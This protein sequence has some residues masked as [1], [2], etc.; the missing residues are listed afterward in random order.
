MRNL[1]YQ[2]WDGPIP[3]GTSHSAAQMKQY[4][5]RIGASHIFEDNPKWI[6]NNA[7]GKY[8][9]HYGQF[10]V[11]FD[12]KFSDNYDKILFVDADVFPTFQLDENVFDQ[13]ADYQDIGICLEEQQPAIRALPEN[14][15]H[16]ISKKWDEKWAK[17]IKQTWNVSMPRN[18]D[19]LL[20]VYNS[21][22]VLYNMNSIKPKLNKF[23]PFLQYV[24]LMKQN[25]MPSFYTCDQPYIHAMLKVANLE[26][27][28][29]DQGWNSFV[30][31]VGKRGTPNRTVL[32][33]RTKD[34]KFVHIQLSGADDFSPLLLDQITDLPQNL[35]EL[36]C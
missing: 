11:L 20:K 4:A 30:H 22:V 26:Y 23:I 13:I 31:Y 6:K 25:G 34:S 1:I 12:K 35:W 32:D 27:C 15:N 9:P 14:A 29:M 18:R 19:G 17:I 8:S 10:K 2:Y 3:S 21:G 5:E 7:L 24:N 28:E 33:L 16:H 36:K